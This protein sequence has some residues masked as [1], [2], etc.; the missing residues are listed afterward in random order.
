M[1]HLHHFVTVLRV[2]RRPA[3]DRIDEAA[4]ERHRQNGHASSVFRQ[5]YVL[6]PSRSISHAAISAAR[7]KSIFRSGT[8]WPGLSVKRF[9]S[10]RLAHGRQVDENDLGTL[11]VA[12]AR[13]LCRLQ[14]PSNWC[15]ATKV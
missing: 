2:I 1:R 11:S 9:I 5:Q 4:S 3:S 8:Q 6:I 15:P 10:N 13:Q 12:A 7:A 14:A